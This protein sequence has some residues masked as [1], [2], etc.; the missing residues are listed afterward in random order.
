MNIIKNVLLIPYYI[1]RVFYVGFHFLISQ[2]ALGFYSYFVWFFEMI[3]K[4]FKNSVKLENIISHYKKRTRQ[5]EKLLFFLFLL[6]CLSTSYLFL[7]TKVDFKN[8]HTDKKSTIAEN[9]NIR[10]M[11]KEFQKYNL[12]DIN[13]K[14]LKDINSDAIGWIFVNHTNINYPVLKTNDNEFYQNH[15]FDKSDNDDGWIF[16]DYRN[17]YVD[18]LENTIIYGKELDNKEGFSNIEDMF[19]DK[20]F[21]S[22]DRNIKF[23]TNDGTYNYEVFSIY[24]ISNNDISISPDFSSKEEYYNFLVNIKA[25]STRDFLVNVTQDD[26]IL[27]LMTISASEEIKVVHAKLIIE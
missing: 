27:T 13:F 22:N 11:Y 9:K 3:H 26:K 5:P 19:S 24:S 10:N 18:F 17:N 15:Y 20:Y 21:N 25:L 7:T 2:I 1:L 4:I 16:M 23:I 8:S 6:V 12:F 14:E